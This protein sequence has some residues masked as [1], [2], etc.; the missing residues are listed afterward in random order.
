MNVLLFLI[1]FGLGILFT[2]IGRTMEYH[3]VDAPSASGADR[4][5]TAAAATNP[6]ARPGAG[7]STP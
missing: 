3:L 6:T 1:A 5:A 4:S 7:A 2:F